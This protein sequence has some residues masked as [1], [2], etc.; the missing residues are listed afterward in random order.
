MIENRDSLT[1]VLGGVCKLQC[2]HMMNLNKTETMSSL[3]YVSFVSKCN[4]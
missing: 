2:C 4:L 3:F 1:S